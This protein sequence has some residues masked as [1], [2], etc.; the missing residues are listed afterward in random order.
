M[1][2]KPLFPQNVRVDS[3]SWWRH[4]LVP[5]ITPGPCECHTLPSVNGVAKLWREPCGERVDH[6]VCLT[7]MGGLPLHRLSWTATRRRMAPERGVS[8]SETGCRKTDT[9]N[10]MADW[11]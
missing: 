1:P 3:A 2:L 9:A 11:H 10:A 7:A 8:F 5:R 4:S 6:P